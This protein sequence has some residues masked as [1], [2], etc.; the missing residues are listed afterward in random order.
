MHSKLKVIM[1]VVDTG[2]V[3]HADNKRKSAYWLTLFRMGVFGAAHG[4]GGWFFWHS[5]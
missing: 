1:I 2:R 3:V 4:S 5:P